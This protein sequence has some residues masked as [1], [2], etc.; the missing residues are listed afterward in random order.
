MKRLFTFL[1]LTLALATAAAFADIEVNIRFSDKRI[2]YPGSEISI[3]VG[4]TNSTTS[5]FRFRLAERRLYNL[6]FDAVTP[7]NRSLDASPAFKKSRADSGPVYFRELS[8]EPGE[9][10]AFVERLDDYVAVGES[11]TF[12][13]RAL[14]WPELV[15]REPGVASAPL[16]SNVLILSVRPPVAGTTSVAESIKKETGEILRPE[17]IGPDEVVRRTIEARQRSRWNEFFLYL[18]LEALL[19]RSA[20]LSRQYDRESDAGRARLLEK[21]R[22]DLEG[23]RSE[24]PIVTLPAD[25][26]IIETRYGPTSGFVQVREKFQEKG[27]RSIKDYEYELRRREGLW[28]IVGYTVVNKGTE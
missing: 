26:E 8:I 17:A 5:T 14:F 11:G 22:L 19:R 24:T 28:F 13:V 12:S 7:T 9:E 2:Y 16:E 18:D 20:E 1:T 25:F 23:L 15:P 21:F 27:F 3:R 10:Y 6:E 4:I